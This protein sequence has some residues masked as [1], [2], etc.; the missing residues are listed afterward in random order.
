MAEAEA[1]VIDIEEDEWE[2]V[3]IT[4]RG[5]AQFLGLSN[6][7]LVISHLNL[8]HCLLIFFEDWIPVN[9][10]REMEME[11][12]CLSAGEWELEELGFWEEGKERGGVAAM[13]RSLLM[14]R[15]RLVTQKH[16]S[17][18]S[19]CWALLGL[20]VWEMT[21]ASLFPK[22]PSLRGND[23]FSALWYFCTLRVRNDTHL[24]VVE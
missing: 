3:G 10:W 14:L 5:S 11:E 20:W 16:N 19:F 4:R 21:I 6:S 17:G 1:A 9:L 18:C 23:T 12:E 7:K 24:A 15:C 22:Y 8:L 2:K 13:W